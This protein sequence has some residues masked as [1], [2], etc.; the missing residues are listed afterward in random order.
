MNPSQLA[1]VGS[2]T[3]D[4]AAG[5]A[6]YRLDGDRNQA[7]RLDVTTEDD[8]SF[9]AVHPDLDVLYAVSETAAGSVVAYE[10]D[11]ET[12]A[13]DA[14]HRQPSGDAGPC[15]L[16]V[17]PTGRFLFVAHYAG[18]SVA[19]LPIADDGR[20]GEPTA[21]VEHSG[22]S[23]HPDRQTSPHPHSVVLGPENR[24]LYVPDL[25]TDR[26]ER[27]EFD[28]TRGSLEAAPD[29]GIE[30]R[31]GAGPRHLTFG[32]DGRAGYLCTELDSTLT[33]LER[34][35]ASGSLESR[36]AIDTLPPTVDGESTAADVQVHPSGR[37]V[38]ASNRGHDSVAIFGVRDD[39]TLEARGHE[40]TR[41]E[42]PRNLALD[43]TGSRLFA[44][45]RTGDRLVGF[46]I[47]DE[48][49][50]LEPTGLVESISRP[51]CVRIVSR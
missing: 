32:P 9:L 49:G 43:P 39:G 18:G 29:S 25:G 34:D 17:D 15:H 42:T 38:Y 51:A 47:D 40:P 12:G 48:T 41:G 23:V 26:V 45:N 1:F 7:T 21:L 50:G 35:P 33:V 14:L 27:Y 6:S 30:I 11:R 5:L 22:S 36:Q 28:R 37:W 44:A 3:D 24:V 10:F 20:P 19:V 31:D 2:Y 8:P 13:L 16:A 46:R 4:G